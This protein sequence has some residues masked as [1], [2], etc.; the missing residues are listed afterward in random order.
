MK[1]K[2]NTTKLL[3][4][5]HVP[6]SRTCFKK[7]FSA[8]ALL[9]AEL[10]LL[11][12]GGLSTEAKSEKRWN[13]VAR[14]RFPSQHLVWRRSSLGWSLQPSPCQHRG[15]TDCF[16]VLA[17]VPFPVPATGEVKLVKQIQFLGYLVFYKTGCHL[18]TSCRRRRCT[19]MTT[20]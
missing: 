16:S 1:C 11:G 6:E 20:Y 18:F 3:K 9:K 8:S 12:G 10:K 17:A 19:K 5:S 2:V 13:R 14:S 4:S 7:R 15:D